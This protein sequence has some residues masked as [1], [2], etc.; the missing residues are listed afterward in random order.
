M[1]YPILWIILFS[2]LAV[3]AVAIITVLLE[4]RISRSLYKFLQ[5]FIVVGAA[6]GLCSFLTI[7]IYFLL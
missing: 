5:R 4:E 1:L 2:S 3:I 6:I 7:G